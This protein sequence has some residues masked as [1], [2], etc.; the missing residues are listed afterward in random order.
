LEKHE[1]PFYNPH[2]LSLSLSL[3]L[4]THPRTSNLFLSA[5]LLSTTRAMAIATTI[6]DGE[7]EEKG[8]RTK[9]LGK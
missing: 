4:F 8:V 5:S 6:A 3:F 9:R 7:E 1:N 2:C